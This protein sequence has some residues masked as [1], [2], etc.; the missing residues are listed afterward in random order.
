MDVESSVILYIM[1]FAIVAVAL[2]MAYAEI[3]QAL[4]LKGSGYAWVKWC[5]GIMGLYWAVYYLRSIIGFELGITHQIWV[6]SPLLLT[7]AFVAAGAILSL[8]RGRS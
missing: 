8:R 4:R 2:L 7:L 6:R 1:K 5:L 3:R